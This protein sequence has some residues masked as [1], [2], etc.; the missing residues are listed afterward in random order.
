MLFAKDS[1]SFKEGPI[2]IFG[3]VPQIT[4]LF[5]FSYGNKDNLSADNHCFAKSTYFP[6]TVKEIE[7]NQGCRN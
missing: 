7:D 1:C 4:D 6:N 3:K 2:G 5:I